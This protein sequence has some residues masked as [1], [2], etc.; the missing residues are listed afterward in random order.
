MSLD[1]KDRELLLSLAGALSVS[2]ANLARDPCGDWNMVGRRGHIS[3]DGTA[4]YVYLAPGT[5]RRCES[6]KCVLS[7][8]TVHQDGDDEGVLKLVG[9]PTAEQAETLRK[10]VGLRKVTPLTDAQRSNLRRFSF[11]R[12]KTPLHHQSVA[13]EAGGAT[14]LA[15]TTAKAA[16]AAA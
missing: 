2:K 14:T 16:H 8:A 6:A 4:L 11:A 12:D 10:L 5:V 3:T 7:F 15:P 1:R 9:F 13:F